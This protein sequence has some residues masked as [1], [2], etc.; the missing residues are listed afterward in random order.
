[1]H[2]VRVLQA[3][4]SIGSVQ[5]RGWVMTIQ[6]SGVYFLLLLPTSFSKCRWHW[7]RS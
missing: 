2:R 1:M 4:E 7:E 3:L 6:D 5:C